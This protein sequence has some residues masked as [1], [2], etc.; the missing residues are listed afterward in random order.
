MKANAAA[1]G[2]YIYTENSDLYGMDPYIQDMVKFHNTTIS[3]P[4]I[5]CT[6]FKLTLGFCSFQFHSRRDPLSGS[7]DSNARAFQKVAE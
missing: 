7:G 5:K 2:Q 4:L 6:L 3:I 1:E